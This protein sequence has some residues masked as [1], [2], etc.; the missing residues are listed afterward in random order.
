MGWGDKNHLLSKHWISL[1][2][3]GRRPSKFEPCCIVFIFGFFCRQLLFCSTPSQQCTASQTRRAPYPEAPLCTLPWKHP[4][5][6][7]PCLSRASLH[8]SAGSPRR[9]PKSTP[10]KHRVRLDKSVALTGRGV[11]ARIGVHAG[12]LQRGGSAQPHGVQARHSRRAAI[13]SPESSRPARGR[14]G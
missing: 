5:A 8:P 6:R 2:G 9:S 10:D 7:G 12:G 14:C 11:P 13:A 3:L 4:R 1:R